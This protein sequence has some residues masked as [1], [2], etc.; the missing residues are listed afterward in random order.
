MTHDRKRLPRLREEEKT[1]SERPGFNPDE[2][3]LAWLARR[4][5]KNGAPLIT[6]PEFDAGEKLRAD[7]TFSE[8]MPHVTASWSGVFVD[9]G[10]RSPAGYGVDMS[11]HVVAARLRVQMALKAVGP[12]LSGILIDVC[13]YLKGLEALEKA[14]GWPQR[15]GKIV[16]QIALQRLARHYGLVPDPTRQER[17]ASAAR[18]NHWA[19]PDYRPRI[20]PGA[21]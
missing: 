5:D 10:R 17:G 7:F 2:S 19:A 8:M 3:P 21:N 15:S 13:C 4:K 9:S 14:S 16:L 6:K 20:E 12:E 1:A 18:V 11:D